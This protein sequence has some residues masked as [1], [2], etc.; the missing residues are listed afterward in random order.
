MSASKFKVEAL[1]SR[2]LMSS[3]VLGANGVL[4]VLGTRGVN[5]TVVV[6][7]GAGGVD[8]TVNG[9][10]AKKAP[11]AGVKVVRVHGFD[12]NDSITVNS[13]VPATLKVVAFG[14][15]GNDTINANGGHGIISGEAGA[16]SLAADN[17][18]YFL[19][20][21]P[22][23]DTI[24]AT[25]GAG[26]IIHGGGGSDVITVTGGGKNLIFGGSGG[27]AVNVSGGTDTV[28]SGSGRDNVIADGGA[29]ALLFDLSGGDTVTGNTN[30][31]AGSDTIFTGT[32]ED[33]ITKGPND[34]VNPGGVHHPRAFR[35]LV[36]F[37]EVQEIVASL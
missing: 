26:D 12:G 18:Q 20:G 19:S 31:S 6:S 32:G 9:T 36:A 3:V 28:I 29:N 30:S 2:K 14:G 24:I 37:L 1:E 33:S 34:V 22:G 10:L 25:G 27:N 23:G 8:V 17:A 13:S 15:G 35:K 11:F 21:G 4:H 16:D 5:N 7:E